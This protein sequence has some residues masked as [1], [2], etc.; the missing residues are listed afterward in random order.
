MAESC[1]VLIIFQDKPLRLALHQ[2]FSRFGLL[3]LDL[4]WFRPN[5]KQRFA[6]KASCAAIIAAHHKTRWLPSACWMGRRNGILLV[7]SCLEQLWMTF[8][9]IQFQHKFL[10]WTSN[11]YFISFSLRAASSA[12]YVQIPNHNL[13]IFFDWNVM[14]LIN[15]HIVLHQ[16]EVSH[17]GDFYY[18]VNIDPIFDHY[19]RS[20]NNRLPS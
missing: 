6:R 5:E 17:D 13:Y 14:L 4:L 9:C 1:R 16:L 19:F 18:M 3:R 2:S 11:N 8:P 12:K 15:Y 10:Y 20:Y 7:S